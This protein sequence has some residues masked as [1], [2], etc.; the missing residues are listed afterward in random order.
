M[1]I[2]IFPIR[3][4][5]DIHLIP[6]IRKKL[7]E[8]GSLIPVK[9]ALRVFLRVDRKAKRNFSIVD[10]KLNVHGRAV[11]FTGRASTFERAIDNC[12]KNLVKKFS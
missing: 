9:T 11:F 1:N 2:N 12:I 8:A 5:P 3:I 10:L 4:K 7:E 6:L